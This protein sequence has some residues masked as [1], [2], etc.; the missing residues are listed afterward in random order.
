MGEFII[1]G[2][3]QASGL[4]K[5]VT[6]RLVDLPVGTSRYG[7]ILNDQA[8]VVDDC[9]VFRLD[10]EKWF[11]VVNGATTQK[12]AAHVQKHLSDAARFRD[13]SAITG[14]VDIQGPASRDVLRRLVPEID[15]LSYFQFDFFG[16]L[17]EN[18]L[19]SRTG[20][21]GELGYEIFF[22]WERTADLWNA[23]LSL[24]EVKPAGLG[25]RDMLRLEVGYSLYGHELNEDINPLEAGLK[26]FVDFEK[27]FIGKKALLAI[28]EKGLSRSIAGFISENRR[29]PRENHRIFSEDGS[30]IGYVTSG[31]YSPSRHC[32]IG[33]GFVGKGHEKKGKKIIFG[34]EK[35]RNYAKISGKIFFKDGSLKS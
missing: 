10:K 25:A 22:P 20:Y 27:D 19:I 1:E 32:G 29:S 13:V 24:P 15:R 31:T 18:V 17:G 7:M 11:M 26:R 35:N 3:A 23:V 34:D 33:L 30:E 2:D 21:T 6:M 28:Q 8:G 16:L 12:D 4:D 14:K 9:I 5:I